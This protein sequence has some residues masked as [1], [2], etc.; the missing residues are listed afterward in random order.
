MSKSTQQHDPR[1]L[2]VAQLEQRLACTKQ[3]IWRWYTKGD[4]PKPHYLGQNRVWFETDVE[5]WEQKQMATRT[6]PPAV[7][8]GAAA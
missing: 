5:A 6:T 1:R 4:F 2:T 3:T 7:R 8:R